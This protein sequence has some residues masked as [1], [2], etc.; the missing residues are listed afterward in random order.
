MEQLNIKAGDKLHVVTSHY[1]ITSYTYVCVH[2]KNPKYHILL[3][4]TQ[5]PIRMYHN[6]LAMCI[7]FGFG[8]YDTAV[9]VL[10]TRLEKYAAYVRWKLIKSKELK[11]YE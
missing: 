8:D 6:E 9:E 3:N 4:D 7:K 2:P 1:I 10:V 5:E 11:Q